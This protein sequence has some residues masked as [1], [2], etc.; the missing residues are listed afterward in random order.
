MSIYSQSQYFL[1]NSP[2][3]MID[4][5]SNNSANALWRIQ[6][7]QLSNQRFSLNMLLKI[8]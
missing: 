4:Q 3:L 2:A 1:I 7:M 8:F 6:A 5:F